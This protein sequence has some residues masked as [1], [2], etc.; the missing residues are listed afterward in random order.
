[1]VASPSLAELAALVGDQEITIPKPL[2]EGQLAAV[3]ETMRTLNA[4]SNRIDALSG[5]LQGCKVPVDVAPFRQVRDFL[6]VPYAK[7]SK[8]VLAH[9]DAGGKL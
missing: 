5:E 6:D 9:L 7:L 1:M 2:S 4:A 8:V 3:I